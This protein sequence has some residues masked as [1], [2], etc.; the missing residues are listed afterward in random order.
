MIQTGGNRESESEHWNRLLYLAW[1]GTLW[2]W[3]LAECLVV[4]KGGRC[5]PKDSFKE[6]GGAVGIG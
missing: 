6:V 3:G 2:K 1:K 4:K 5:D